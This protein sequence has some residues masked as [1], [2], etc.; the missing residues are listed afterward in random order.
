MK[1]VYDTASLP[2][3]LDPGNM[4]KIYEHHH[5][6]YWDSSNGGT[7]PQLYNEDGTKAKLSIVDTAGISMNMEEYSKAFKDAEYWEKE[8]YKCKNSPHYFWANYGTPTYPHTQDGLRKYLSQAGLIDIIEKDSDKAKKMWEKQK[9]KLKVLTDTYT[10]EFL[11]ERRAA[12]QSIIAEY[13]TK[14]RSLEILLEPFVKLYDKNGIELADKKRVVVLTEKIYMNRPVLKKY[15][16]IYRTSKGKWDRAILNNT[17]YCTLLEIFY[18]ILKSNNKIKDVV[19]STTEKLGGAEV[20][21][22]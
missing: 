9:E 16:D 20:H 12:M 17:S 8:L 18:D 6:I 21:F 2:K 1:L 10:I 5:V 3:G 11:K 7:K 14:T 13:D 19:D 22:K 4:T 15:S